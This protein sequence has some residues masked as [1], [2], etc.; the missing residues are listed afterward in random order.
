MDKLRDLSATKFVDSGFT[1]PALEV[2][3]VSNAGK[4]TEKIQI[5]ANGLAKRDGDSTLYQ[6][7][8]NALDDLRSAANGVQPEQAATSSDSKKK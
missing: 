8:A 5:A 2:T 7:A 3:V 6:L 1:S 4:R